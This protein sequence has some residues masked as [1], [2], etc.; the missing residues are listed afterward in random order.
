MAKTAKAS[1]PDPLHRD[2]FERHGCMNK[3]CDQF[4]DEPRIVAPCHPDAPVV[5]HY[6]RRDGVL[7]ISCAV[8]S[9]IV[10]EIAVA[11]MN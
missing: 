8:C 9:L 7:Q 10:C 6:I 11:A 4:H 5:A 1:K 3:E 2:Q